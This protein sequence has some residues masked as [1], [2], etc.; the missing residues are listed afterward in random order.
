MD[1]L[2]VAAGR[3]REGPETALTRDYLARANS[4]GRRLGLAFKLIEIE[5]KP[6]GDM[7]REAAETLKATP[8]G[9][10]RA[11]LDERGECLGSRALAE[12]LAAWRD[13]GR[14]ALAFW[15]GG[16]DGAAQTL[17]DQADLKLAFGRATWPHRLV[18]AML[19]EQLYRASTILGQSPYH[20]D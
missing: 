11:L 8:E 14:P 2:I 17:K 19:A 12:K 6:P 15:I 20:R 13:Q 9:A 10:V 5:A 7:R 4:A 1:I 3:L 18:R 16:A